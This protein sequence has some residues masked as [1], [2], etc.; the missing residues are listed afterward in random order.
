MTDTKDET[1]FIDNQSL[2]DTTTTPVLDHDSVDPVYQA[3]AHVLN[4]AIQ[5]IGMGKYQWELVR[6]CFSVPTSNTA[7]LGLGRS[8]STRLRSH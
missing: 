2:D 7:T 3:K 8:V 4:N 1:E 6:S 5:Q